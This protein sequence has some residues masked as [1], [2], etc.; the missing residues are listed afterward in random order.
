LALTQTRCHI[1]SRIKIILAELDAP[2]IE[3]LCVAYAAFN[4]RDIGAALATMT[5]DVSWP[6]TFKGGFVHGPEA[7]CADWTEPWSAIDARVEPVALHL[8]DDRQILVE[9]H[10]VVRDRA[11]A[12]LADEPVGHRFTFEQGLIK[13]MA[14]AALV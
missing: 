2:A 6:R 10:P 1:P 5:A 4:A 12:I 3:R 7:I 13:A 11:V 14:I 8:K 9:V